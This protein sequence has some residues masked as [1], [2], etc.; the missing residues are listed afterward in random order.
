M[1]QMPAP[2]TASM[3]YDLITC[4]HRVTQ[5]LF[6]NPGARDEI[7][8]F[9]QLLWEKGA[10]HERKTIGKRCL[11]GTCYS[12]WCRESLGALGLAFGL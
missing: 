12:V 6:G 2:V 8:P 7:N 3:L 1:G 5:D 11:E 4:P 9:V 10:L